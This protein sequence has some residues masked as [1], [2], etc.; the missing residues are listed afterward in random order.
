MEQLPTLSKFLKQL[1]AVPYLASKNIFRVADYFMSL[2]DERFKQFLKTLEEMHERLMRCTQ[3]WSWKESDRPCLYCD[4]PRRDKKVICVVETWHDLC[5]IERTSSY[6]GMYH[7]LGGALCP[8]DGIGPENLTIESLVSRIALGCEE[9][10]LAMNQTPE[11][12]ATAAFIARRLRD[13]PIKITCLARGIPVG[14][15]L[16]GMDRLTVCKALAERRLF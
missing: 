12:E 14:S 7:V 8:L 5:A 2:D 13:A 15:T 1:Q 6:A 10:I 11:G 9:I 4:A 16:D 3:C